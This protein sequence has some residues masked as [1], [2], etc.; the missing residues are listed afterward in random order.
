MTPAQRGLLW[1]Y[2]AILALWPIRHA[3][4]SLIFRTLDFLTP[5]S[6]R[7]TG[8]GPLAPTPPA[9]EGRGGGGMAG[10][11]GPDE[12]SAQPP[13]RPDPPPRGERGP[14]AATNVLPLV[15]AIIPAK[16]EEATIAAC[17]ASVCAQDYPNLEILVVDDRST[18]R[19]AEIACG[20]AAVDSR[21]RVVAIEHLPPGW[22]GK[23][24]ALHVAA[25]GARGE[26]LWFVDAD[27]LHIP[28]CLAIALEY[29]RS[30]GAALMSLLPELRCESFW[31]EAVQP[32]ASIVLMQ[33]FPLFRVHSPKSRRFFANGQ[34]ILVR[35]DAYDAAGGH[36]AV[37]DRFVEDIYLGGN[38]KALG[39]PIRVGMGKAISSTRMYTSLPQIIRG[40]ARILYDAVDRRPGPLVVKVLDQLVFNQTAH[41][42]LVAAL[43]MLW[44]GIPGPFPAILL[45]M[46]VA[47]HLLAASVLYRLYRQMVARPLRAVL[48]YPVAEFVLDA[49]L[50]QAIASCVTGRV[51]WR[52]TAYGSSAP[53]RSA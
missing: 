19:T 24:H 46:S 43:V 3:A 14:E 44:M 52:G 20:V 42:A 45:G 33:S 2:G 35:R 34:F 30:E 23:T 5:R 31:E 16:D 29:A 28:P 17:L 47:H 25:A 51:T 4:L 39:L 32:L 13:P 18:D 48:W 22:T 1:A 37:R 53:S 15:S 9:G 40:W 8:A 7:F 21:V 38:V 50:V 41:V 11:G 26:W 6:P 12:R 27:T 49:I 36:A 10:R